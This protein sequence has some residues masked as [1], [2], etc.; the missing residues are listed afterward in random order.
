[1]SLPL[2]VWMERQKRGWRVAVIPISC[3]PRHQ[4]QRGRR[5]CAVKRN[6]LNLWRRLQVLLLLLLFLQ[7]ELLQQQTRSASGTGCSVSA[8]AREL[9]K[10]HA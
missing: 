8:E 5:N 10:V 9:A 3:W 2:W 6:P 7:T 4:S 1:M